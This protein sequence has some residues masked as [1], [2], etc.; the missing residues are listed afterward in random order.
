MAPPLIHI[1]YHKTGTTW[2]QRH[3]FSDQNAGFYLM[4]R[5]DIKDHIVHI[6]ALVFD[7]ETCQETLAHHAQKASELGLQLVVSQERLSGGLHAGAYDSKENADRLAEVYPSAKILIVIREQREMCI[8]AYKQYLRNGGSY[9]LDEYLAPRRRERPG[10]NLG[11]FNYDRL[12]RYYISLF[13]KDNVCVLPFEMFRDAPSDFLA[14]ILE[15]CDVEQADPA[16]F[17]AATDLKENATRTYLRNVV[18]RRLN[19]F[20]IKDH[21][22][23]GRILYIPGFRFVAEPFLWLVDV[24]SPQV[25]EKYLEQKFSKVVS[26][27]TRGCYAESNR[28]TSG[29]IGVDLAQYGYEV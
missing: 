3:V 22:N 7:P 29:L 14:A 1:G 12:I 8:S 16:H 13:G 4:P 20:L 6:N 11:H 27:R 5:D 24:L 15:F 10:F 19:P 25:L 2:L 21:D 26:E 18:K 9:S 17:L 23:L 28:L